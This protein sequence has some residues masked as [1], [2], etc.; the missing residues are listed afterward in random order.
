M[1]PGRWVMPLL[2]GPLSQHGKPFS[3]RGRAVTGE[4]CGDCRI[5][6]QFEHCGF[7]TRAFLHF[8]VPLCCVKSFRRQKEAC[9]F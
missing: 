4:R 1:R 8:V 5:L 3:H 2:G 7:G 6:R 9:A